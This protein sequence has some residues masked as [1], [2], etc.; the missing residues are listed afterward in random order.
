MPL[1]ASLPENRPA[2]LWQWALLVAVVTVALTLAPFIFTRL[3]WPDHI[4]STLLV[5]MVLAQT[6]GFAVR[7]L[8]KMRG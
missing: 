4:W 7:R 1:P 2:P 6:L 3:G 5:A 8:I